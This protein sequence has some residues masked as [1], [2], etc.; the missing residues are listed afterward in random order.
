MKTSRLSQHYF[1]LQV[2]ADGLIETRLFMRKT[3]WSSFRKYVL[4]AE[5]SVASSRHEVE[6]ILSMYYG[7]L[8]GGILLGALMIPGGFFL[9][10]FISRGIDHRSIGP[11]VI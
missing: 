9:G 10:E 7:D 2:H 11:T 1:T 3:T 5:N 4:V 8:G 6:L